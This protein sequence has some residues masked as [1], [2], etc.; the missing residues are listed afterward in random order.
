MGKR[1]KPYPNQNFYRSRKIRYV[2]A[3]FSSKK[4]FIVPVGAFFWSCYVLYFTLV[5]ATIL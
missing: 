5:I 1:Y 3:A 4:L 2:T